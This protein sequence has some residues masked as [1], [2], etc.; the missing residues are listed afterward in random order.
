M[1]KRIFA[2]TATLALLGFGIA[3]RAD[4]FNLGSGYTNLETVEVGDAGNTADTTGY[5]SVSYNYNIGKYEVT[6]K[7]YCDFLNAKAKTDTYGLYSSYMWSNK[8]GCKIQQSGT[9]GNFSYSVTDDYANRPVNYVSYYDAC[10]FANWLNNGQG[11][12]DT[13][14]GA[15]TMTSETITRS[16]DYKWAVT[17]EDEWYKAAYYKGGETDAGYW[18]YPTQSDSVDTYRANYYNSTTTDVGLYACPSAYGTF[19]QGGNVME[20]NEEL[21]SNTSHKLRGGSFKLDREYLKS[22]QSLSSFST[23][24]MPTIGFRVVQAVPEPSSIIALLGGI[25]S[26]LA[27]KRRKS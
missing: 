4:V 5:G 20:W 12:G 16:A 27:S 10:R 25:G 1:T 21:V 3:G 14:T 24:E 8:Y 18:L 13:E 19:D 22:S 9:S 26:L 6:S 7:Q 17:S 11:N 23:D 2:V 15:Y